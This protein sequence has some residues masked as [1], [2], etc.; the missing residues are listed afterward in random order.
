MLRNV[1]RI[2]NYSNLLLTVAA[3]RRLVLKSG[4][5]TSAFLQTDESLEDQEPTVWSPPELAALFGA[6][7]QDPRALR[8][9]RAF[10]GLVHAPRQWFECVVALML[11]TGWIQSKGDK[12]ANSQDEIVGV[13]GVARKTAQSISKPSRACRKPS[14]SLPKREEPKKRVRIKHVGVRGMCMDV[15]V[16]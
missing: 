11:R 15:L 8:A 5:V 12:C 4:D 9:L 14:W 3:A 2:L 7:P 16:R 13:A 1:V 10:Y 6:D